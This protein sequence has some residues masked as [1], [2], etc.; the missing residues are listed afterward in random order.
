MLFTFNLKKIIV[1]SFFIL[2][3]MCGMASQLS[4]S[5][6]EL[7]SKHD[8]FA[9][10]KKEAKTLIDS[11]HNA[12]QYNCVLAEDTVQALK[13]TFDTYA[14]GATKSCI[15]DMKTEKAL[16]YK[17]IFAHNQ[18]QTTKLQQ[19]NYDLFRKKGYFPVKF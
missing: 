5:P 11:L 3:P 13:K 12:R 4:L 10:F 16:C 14:K 15:I 18:K 1:F 7:I 17:K 9:Q 6:I 2:I 19:I 8:N